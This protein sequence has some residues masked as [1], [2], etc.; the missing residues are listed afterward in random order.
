MQQA[1]AYFLKSTRLGFRCWTEED[2]PLALALWGDP[3]V[4]RF[5]G[6]PFPA[7]KVKERLT[8]HIAMMSAHNIQYW[9]FFL[10]ANDVFVGCA[11][12]RPYQ[13]E[14]K[15]YELGAHLLPAYWG[16]GFAREASEVIIDLAFR[17]LGANGLYA[18]HHPENAASRALLAK[19]GFR[20]IGEEFYTPTRVV[21]PTY[22]LE[23]PAR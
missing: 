19:L 23:P 11:G 16:Q 9:P 5:I 20:H 3:Q 14:K 10:L 13:P 8:E 6:G 18:G 1:N 12:L 21:E 4:G 17:T 2:L 7:Q 15:I 22:L